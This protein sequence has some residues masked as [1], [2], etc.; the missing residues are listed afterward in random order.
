MR[1]QGSLKE[2]LQRLMKLL[3]NEVLIYSDSAGFS[4]SVSH[5]LADGLIAQQVGIP[6][7]DG[8]RAIQQLVLDGLDLGDIVDRVDLPQPFQH[9]TALL[10]I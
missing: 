6:G 4:R 2:A 7:D 9:R 10:C 5:T 1:L 3:T 8:M